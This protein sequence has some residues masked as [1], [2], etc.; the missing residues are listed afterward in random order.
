MILF[1]FMSFGGGLAV[2][3][4]AAQLLFSPRRRENRCLAALFL[5]VGVLQFQF[6][7]KYSGLNGV[8]PSSCGRLF[9]VQLAFIYVLGPLCLF[10]LRASQD[11]DFPL[12]RREARH[13]LPAAVLLLLELAVHLS[14]GGPG[15]S[16]FFV[17]AG[18][19][20][21]V[22]AGAFRLPAIAGFGL[23]LAYLLIQTEEIV[24]N[25]PVR[26]MTPVI[27][28]TLGIYVYTE[29]FLVLILLSYLFGLPS[30]MRTG[31]LM[32]PALMVALYLT[33]HRRPELLNLFRQEIRKTRYQRSKLTGLD[34]DDLHR[35][36]VALME[37]DKLYRE[38]DISLQKVAGR[39][40]LTPHQLS[41]F[42]NSHLQVNFNTFVNRYRIEEAKRLLREDP[43]ETILAVAFAVGFNSRSTFNATFQSFTGTTPSRY[44]KEFGR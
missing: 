38:E 9:A 44:R 39:L 6:G 2:L 41:E 13:F 32:I 7:I 16:N 15:S 19:A 12:A 28:L 10:Y 43:G 5:C 42:L 40:R 20:R 8:L 14:A 3:M 36:L 37:E 29:C 23:T 30:L 22:T 18:L 24:K 34:T 35:R 26:E 4:A 25:W 11:P 1:M 17:Q 27:R 21:E 33:G 31:M